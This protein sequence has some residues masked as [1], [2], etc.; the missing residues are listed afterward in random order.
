[1]FTI[2]VKKIIILMINNGDIVKISDTLI[3]IFKVTFNDFYT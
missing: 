3:E 2:T 1:M